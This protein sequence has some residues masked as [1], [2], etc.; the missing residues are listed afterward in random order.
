ME[1]SS[2][3]LCRTENVHLTAICVLAV[4]LGITDRLNKMG[5]FPDWLMG[6]S[7]GDLAR[8]VYSGA[9]NFNQ[10]VDYQYQLFLDYGKNEERYRGVNLGIRAPV[11]A[12][13]LKSDLQWFTDNALFV[14]SMSPRFLQLSC[15]PTHLEMVNQHAARK[16]WRISK[17]GIEYILHTSQLKTISQQAI[18]SLRHLPLL[19]PRFPIYS[20]ILNLPINTLEELRQETVQ[21]LW[22]PLQWADAI[23]SLYRK[24][25]VDQFIN[26]GP[27]KSLSALQRE[28]TP[29]K[30]A[31]EAIGLTDAV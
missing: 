27:C 28:I 30:R 13:F 29:K 19:Q 23:L 12:P 22:K 25:R 26:I 2:A 21:Q 1:K 5:V 16:N 18:N 31:V 17:T 24:H 8:S 20:S 4:Q 9:A 14:S 7:L 6:C 3:E 10:I 15:A 11:K